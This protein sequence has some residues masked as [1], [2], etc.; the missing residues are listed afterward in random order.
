MFYFHFGPI[1]NEVLRQISTGNAVD[2]MLKRNYHKIL[3]KWSTCDVW[4]SEIIRTAKCFM[5]W[6]INVSCLFRCEKEVHTHIHINAD[7]HS[8]TANCIQFM[9]HCERQSF[10]NRVT[11]LFFFSFF[12]HFH[13][14]EQTP[15]YWTAD[16]YLHEKQ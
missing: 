8:H 15:N 6:S 9:V 13:F 11:Q 5:F 12:K 16:K 3:W 1:W 2:L 4:N 14:F 10:N 7:F